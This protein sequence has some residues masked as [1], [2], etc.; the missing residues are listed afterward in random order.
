MKN[1]LLVLLLFGCCSAPQLKAANPDKY[2]IIPKPMSIQEM[3]GHFEINRKTTLV[4]SDQLSDGSIEIFNELI[5]STTGKTLTI[6]EADGSKSNTISFNIRGDKGVSG[7]YRLEINSDHV[8]IDASDEVGAFYGMQSLMQLI[9][10]SDRV[11]SGKGKVKVP[12]VLVDDKPALGYRGLMLDL[13]RYYLPLSM[14]R[15]YIDIMALYKMNNLHLHLTD[16]QGWRVEIKKYPK[17]QSVAA[18]RKETIAGHKNDVP[19]IY[20]GKRH[21]GFYSQNELRDLV[22]YASDRYI[23]IIPEIDMPGHATAALAAYPELGCLKGG[24]EVSTA[25]GI[26]KDVF[27][28]GEFTFEFLEDVLAELVTIF[29][30]KNI[31]IGGD[32]SP[33]DRWKECQECQGN[34]KKWGLKDEDDLQ[35]YFIS[36][37]S[38]FLESEERNAIFWDWEGAHE[39]ELPGNTVVMSWQGEEAGIMAAKRSIHTIM[40]PHLYTY[41]DYHQT[42]PE[43]MHTEPLSIS[44]ERFIPMEKLYSY[45]VIPA[46][47]TEQ[48]AQYVMGAQASLWSEYTPNEENADFR[49]FPRLL[50]FAEVAWT[51][52]EDKDYDSFKQRLQRNRPILDARKINYRN[53]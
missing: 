1:T 39:R 37:I 32:E 41:M 49:L 33:R 28:T 6:S 27:C 26:H 50:A 18:W 51:S 3:K 52:E 40:T 11:K 42:S 45:Q 44:P 13:A 16:D 30:S 20:D 38:E 7:A 4:N 34:I 46:V 21:G 31:H 25:W 5:K 47:L 17:L 14:V 53:F 22:K 15:K 12:N 23:T 10:T 8:S 36:R 29:P 2:P 9:L 48:E 24:Y 43:E 19:R 35:A